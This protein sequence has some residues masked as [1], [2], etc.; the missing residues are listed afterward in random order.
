M[1]INWR[2]GAIFV[3]GLALGALA[4]A[5]L[6]GRGDGGE[7]AAASTTATPL[8]TLTAGAPQVDCSFAPIVA[9]AGPDDGTLRVDKDLQAASSGTISALL[10]SGKEAAAA[11]K[12]RDAEAA[13]LMA[14]RSAEGLTNDPVPL[15][16]AQYQLGRHYAQQASL[17]N[18]AQ[19]DELLRRAEGLHASS[20]EA[21]RRHRGP[22]HEK[23]RFAA[24]G[25][26][27]VQQLKEGPVA[28]PAM[29]AASAPAAA[30][31]TRVSGAPAQPAPAA[32][33]KAEPA[34]VTPPVPTETARA[35]AAKPQEARPQAQESAYAAPPAPAPAAEPAGPTEQE[36]QA[37]R[38]EREER[39]AGERAAREAREARERAREERE[40]REARRRAREDREAREG[41]DARERQERAGRP[42]GTAELGA[43]PADARRAREAAARVAPEPEVIEP[44]ATA[45]GDIQ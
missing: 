1:A 36:L 33:A 25:L 37:Q 27:R 19:R 14:C 45:T 20:L 10:L 9:K 35:P 29:A 2:V 38:A 30:G 8:A 24:E 32:A 4:A 42:T 11:G 22:E 44:P 12:A 13:F 16:D 7:R 31:D 6:V 43:A 15:A 17:P 28:V 3:G 34:K 26:Q 40:E 21:Y 18:A 5:V 41:Q 39:E 23:T